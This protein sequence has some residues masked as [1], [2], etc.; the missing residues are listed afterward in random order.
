MD[1]IRKKYRMK[2]LYHIQNDDLDPYKECDVCDGYRTIVQFPK[3]KCM[4]WCCWYNIEKY[5]IVY[6]CPNCKGTGKVKK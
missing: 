6:S 5:I 2:K 1:Q 4:L 3:N